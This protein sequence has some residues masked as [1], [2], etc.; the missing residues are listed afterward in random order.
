MPLASADMDDVLLFDSALLEHYT[1]LIFTIKYSC[2]GKT[3]EE[4]TTVNIRSQC[5]NLIIRAGKESDKDMVIS[6]VLQ[7]IAIRQL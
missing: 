3:Y 5:D 4:V 6:N 2:L 7:E 1:P